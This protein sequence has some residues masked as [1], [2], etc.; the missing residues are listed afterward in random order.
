MNLRR[1][2]L[3]G[4][5][6]AS[7]SSTLLYTLPVRASDDDAAII[8]RGVELRK[9]GRNA[10]AL[11]A[12]QRAFDEH[13]TPR[14]RA[15]IALAE[16]ALGRWL[17]AE[18][19]L[20]EA[21]ANESDPWIRRNVVPLDAALDVI[22]DHLGT[23]VIECSVA[24]AAV[25]LNGVVVGTSPL[26]PSL[27]V[28]AGNSTIQVTLNGYETVERIVEVGPRNE[29]TVS[30]DLTASARR[31]DVIAAVL[32]PPEPGHRARSA[33]SAAEGPS[34]ERSSKVERLPDVTGTVG[35]AGKTRDSS[36]LR[37]MGW[38]ALTASGAFL[39]TGVV[40]HMVRE[41]NVA[42]YNDDARCFFGDLTRDERCGSNRRTA[43]TA[44]TVALVGYATGTAALIAGATLLLTTRVGP[45]SS[46]AFRLAPGVGPRAAFLFGEAPF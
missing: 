6:G 38:V 30:I 43:E 18:S 23:L 35:N 4:L 36:G 37:A 22:R 10:E 44:G 8:H 13:P 3:V 41:R 1:K 31:P 20:V 26:P 39:A 27:R 14:A 28:V 11:L 40:A 17:E 19:G 25:S 46:R 21:L 15:Q 5:I 7:L 24:G 9:E 45:P 2:S 33:S 42:I 16:Q 12:F 32:P 34:Q 29:V